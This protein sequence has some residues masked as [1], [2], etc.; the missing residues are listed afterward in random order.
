MNQRVPRETTRTARQVSVVL[1]QGA[2][3]GLVRRGP[4]VVGQTYHVDEDIAERLLARGFQLAAAD[5][6]AASPPPEAD[7]D[8]GG[9]PINQH[10]ED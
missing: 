6:G 2:V 4:Y 7:A 10:D 1:P 3:P 9:I 8:G 5:R